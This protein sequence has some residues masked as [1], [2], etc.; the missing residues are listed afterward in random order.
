MNFIET[1]GYGV[2]A[3]VSVYK[4][5][6]QPRVA[7]SAKYPNASK[8]DMLDDLIVM[9]QREKLASKQMQTTCSLMH[10]GC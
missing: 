5:F 3:N 9:G 8:N 1:N 10:H 2:G 4:K 6:L 7:I